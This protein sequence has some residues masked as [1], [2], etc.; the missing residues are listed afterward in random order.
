M[1]APVD[2]SLLREG[3]GVTVFAT[4][5]GQHNGNAVLTLSPNEGLISYAFA[6]KELATHTPK[7]L[8]VGDQV[9]RPLGVQTGWV[10]AVYGAQ[11]WVLFHGEPIVLRLSDL[12][13]AP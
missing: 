5:R 13:R 2:L 7:A 10:V 1:D 11:A 6:A 4:Y 8:A 12:E 3:D 9:R